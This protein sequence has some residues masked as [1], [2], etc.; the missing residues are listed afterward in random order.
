MNR[1]E[2]YCRYGEKNQREPYNTTTINNN[3]G[4]YQNYRQ[5]PAPTIFEAWEEMSEFWLGLVNKVKQEYEDKLIKQDKD[6]PF[7][8]GQHLNNVIN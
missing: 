2:K 1:E 6:R 8:K 3:A 5:N 7:L 4:S